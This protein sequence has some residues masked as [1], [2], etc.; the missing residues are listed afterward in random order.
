MGKSHEI[1]LV[2]Q[3]DDLKP[4]GH[5]RLRESNRHI[6]ILCIMQQSPNPCLWNPFLCWCCL[7][8]QCQHFPGLCHYQ[9][10]LGSLKTAEKKGS[11][12]IFMPSCSAHFL[13]A[14]VNLFAKFQSTLVVF[15]L[16]DKLPRIFSWQVQT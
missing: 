14:P 6:S 5:L 3:K 15:Q 8:A 7:L 16:L 13:L 1:Y 4:A 11:F 9:P 12:C 10:V 2:S